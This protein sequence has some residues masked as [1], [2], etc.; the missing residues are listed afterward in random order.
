MR[1]RVSAGLTVGLFVFGVTKV[2]VAALIS[3]TSIVS[4]SLGE[5][6][7]EYQ[8]DNIINHS[9][10]I[11]N[12]ISDFTELP[13]YLS[14]GDTSH[15]SPSL[16]GN[17]G[18][19]SNYGISG[20]IIDFDLGNS[21]QLNTF[22]LWNDND[23]QGILNFELFT[24]NDTSFAGAVSLGSFSAS[25]GPWDYSQSVPLQLFDLNSANGRYVRLQIFDNESGGLVNF[26]EIAF[27]ATSSSPV[28][29]PTTML[30]FGTGIA[31]LAAARRR[32]KVS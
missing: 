3:P 28:P 1:K 11:T 10:L 26:G 31:G 14:S 6:S 27:D 12:F 24:D 13:A 7:S 16:I 5:L 23:Y 20:G 21:Y 2:S 29:E 17:G 32:K 4:N 19:A 25:Y 15:T 18:F 9:G 30:L 8:I 22:L